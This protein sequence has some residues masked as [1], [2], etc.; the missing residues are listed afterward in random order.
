MITIGMGISYYHA[1]GLVTADPLDRGQIYS[2][3]NQVGDSRVPKRVPDHCLGIKPRCF[4]SP[5]KGFVNIRQM[6]TG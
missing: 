2:C 1:Q 4:N 6:P 3:L 5:A